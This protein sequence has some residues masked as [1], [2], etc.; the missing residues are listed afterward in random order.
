MKALILGLLVLTISS[1]AQA[2]SRAYKKISSSEAVVTIHT[3]ETDGTQA[4]FYTDGSSNDQFLQD[5]L[6][7]KSSDF[8]KAAQAIVLENCGGEESDCGEVTLTDSVRTGF[9][10]GGW[11]EAGSAYT[12]FLGFTHNGTG[13]FFGVDYQIEVIEDVVAQ[14]NADYE[15][16]GV[17]IKTLSA[18]IKKI[19]K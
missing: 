14:V 2:E 10:R 7:D 4:I 12:S 1:H 15:Y 9:G 18:T 5:L 19:E 13:R 17:V 11:M 16:S 3:D 6:A 8:Y